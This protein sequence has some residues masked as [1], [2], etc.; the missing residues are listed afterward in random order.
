MS[1]RDSGRGIV[2][3]SMRECEY[4][5]AR[6]SSRES[7]HE[8]AAWLRADG[9]CPVFVPDMNTAFKT[10][11]PADLVNDMF[12]D[13]VWNLDLRM[14]FYE[15]CYLNMFVSMG[16]T[17]LCMCG[18]GVRYLCFNFVAAS[19][20][21]ATEEYLRSQG[22]TPGKDL[23]WASDFQRLIWAPDETEIMV[24][25]FKRMVAEIDVGASRGSDGRK[26]GYRA[27]VVPQGRDCEST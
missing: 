18:R 22:L 13:I 10:E 1:E 3:L 8:L 7:W 20:G 23:P 17:T 16:P 14:A 12:R 19:C 24:R 2:S 11:G 9:W 6:N 27:A 21:S 15:L 25:E 5:T 4:D 26:Q